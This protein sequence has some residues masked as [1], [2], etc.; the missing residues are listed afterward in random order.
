MWEC[1]VEHSDSMYGSE[2]P[3]QIHIDPPFPNLGS[4]TLC[5]LVLAY[6]VYQDDAESM[7]VRLSRNA[8]NYYYMHKSILGVLLTSYPKLSTTIQFGYKYFDYYF[9]CPTQD[10]YK[11]LILKRP[12]IKLK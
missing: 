10:Q 6:S 4:F 8:G 5:N 2:T 12:K 3:N 1:I 9:E 11:Q 7:L